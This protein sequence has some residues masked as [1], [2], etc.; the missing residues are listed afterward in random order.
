MNKDARNKIIKFNKN[1]IFCT[2]EM[3]CKKNI[4]CFEIYSYCGIKQ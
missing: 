4:L 2:K 3:W 1:Y